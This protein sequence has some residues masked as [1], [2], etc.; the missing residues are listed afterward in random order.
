LDVPEIADGLQSFG[1]GRLPWILAGGHGVNVR[2]Q[3]KHQRTYEVS[4]WT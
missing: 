4:N 2:G 3:K 1:S